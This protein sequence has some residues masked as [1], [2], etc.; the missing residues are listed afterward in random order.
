MV[1]HHS[2]LRERSTAIWRRNPRTKNANVTSGTT[3][4]SFR[5]LPDW[6]PRLASWFPSGFHARNAARYPLAAEEEKGGWIQTSN[7]FELLSLAS[8][9]CSIIMAPVGSAPNR[10]AGRSADRLLV[11]IVNGFSDGDA[12]QISFLLPPILSL[13]AKFIYLVNRLARRYVEFYF[14]PREK[15]RRDER[16]KELDRKGKGKKLEPRLAPLFRF[17]A[18]PLYVYSG[19]RI[20]VPKYVSRNSIGICFAVFVC[21]LLRTTRHE[22]QRFSWRF[23]YDRVYDRIVSERFRRN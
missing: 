5:R 3:R 22:F 20:S 14:F 4:V 17:A 10:P 16:K 2:I 8:L 23:N 15:K 7:L 19:I 18:R 11:E 13:S 21:Y 12:R 1:F 6:A 9:V